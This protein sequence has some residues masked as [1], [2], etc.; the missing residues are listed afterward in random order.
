MDREQKETDLK[1]GENAESEKRSEEEGSGEEAVEDAGVT[2]GAD[3]KSQLA[4]P[5]SLGPRR[6]LTRGELRF[7]C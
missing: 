7:N 2:D 4:Q 3:A 1:D 5:L 6:Q